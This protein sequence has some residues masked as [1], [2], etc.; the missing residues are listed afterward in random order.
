[1]NELFTVVPPPE[2]F[3][4]LARRLTPVDR[5][6]AVP[7]EAGLDRV[8][9][10]G[11]LAGET[12][13]AFERSTMDG[14]A[15]RSAETFG[16]SDAAPAYL[17]L[18]GE[19]AMGSRATEPLLPGTA[20]RIHTGA[21]L[22]PGADGVI[23]VEETNLR[24]DEVE[25]LRPAAPFEHVVRIGEDVQRHAPVVRSGD[26]LRA[27]DLGALA[28][29]GIT[30]I[31]VRA[32]PRIAILSTGDEV[33]APAQV[34]RV[35]EVRDV[36]T[37][38]IAAVVTRAGGIPLACG[39]VRDDESALFERAEAA[40]AD[41]DAL[42]LSAGSSVS[43]RDMTARI[44]DRLGSP[45]VLAHGIALRPGKPTVVAV[46]GG[47]PVIGLPGNPTSAFVVAWRLV[48]PMV[49][50]LAGEVVSDD[51]LDDAGVREATLTQN[52]PSRPGR[53]DYV[54]ATLSQRE[55]RLEVTPLFAKSSLIFSLVR[56]QCLIAIPL[57]AAGAPAGS[58]VRVIVP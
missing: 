19:V 31:A 58:R 32:R 48:R 3:A 55:G 41:A 44:I 9:A 26:R 40:L 27:Q 30:R 36:N 34:P 6:E 38:T 52:L 10:D 28:A 29:L 18:D 14:Y 50:A 43:S 16:A 1:M 7:L 45:G 22:P 46:C 56:S 54:P 5:R 8:A 57:D 20:R 33:V 21:M 11:V 23:I 42:V 39:I 25:V 12:L 17:R 24:G 2:A 15:V 51:G 53:E 47:K 37:T 13:P 49:R 35:G 4:I